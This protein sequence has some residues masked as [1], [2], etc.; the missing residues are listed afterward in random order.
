MSR[1]ALNRTVHLVGSIPLE[2]AGAVF[3]LAGTVLGRLCMR[4]PDG[5][6]GVRKNWIGWQ[7]RAFAGQAALEQSAARERDY[8][9][10]PPFHFRAG[11]AP[12]DL[13]FDDLGFAREALVSFEIFDAKQRAGIIPAAARFLVAIPA[14]YAPVYSFIA[15]AHQEQIYPV[16]EAAIIRELE[17]ICA[18]LPCEKLAIQWDVA[19]EMS[20]FEKVYPTP[21]GKPWDVLTGRLAA[22]GDQVPDGVELGY[23]LC[24]GSMNNRH[25][26]EPDDLGMCVAVANVLADTVKRQIDFLH[27]PVPVN[28]SDSGYFSPLE[29]LALAD[30]TEL[31]LGLVHDVDGLA[32]NRAR[33]DAAARVRAD[34]GIGSECGWGRRSAEDAR[35]IMQLHARLA[36]SS[37]A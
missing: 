18:V 20:L 14:P 28:R 4:Y 2:D 5:E 21:V 27:M 25:W 29:Q 23:H 11:K 26:K 35:I 15:Y 34:F 3:D 22:L 9:L 36:D 13:S 30:G 32:G 8:Q 37:S 6:T 33:M 17:M 31:F 7:F 12:G 1:P 10:H 16:Y 19:T 24:Y